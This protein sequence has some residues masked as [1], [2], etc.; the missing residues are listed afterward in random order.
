MSIFNAIPVAR[1]F[2]EVKRDRLFVKCQDCEN[3]H[4]AVYSHESEHGQGAIY[5]VVCNTSLTGC[6]WLTDY[7]TSELLY[8]K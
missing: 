4:E 2:A 7:Y 1:E 3:E 5:A 6:E 8:T